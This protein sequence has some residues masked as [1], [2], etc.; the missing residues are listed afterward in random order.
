MHDVMVLA[1]IRDVIGSHVVAT[2]HVVILAHHI[3]SVPHF[4]LSKAFR[5]RI[6]TVDFTGVLWARLTRG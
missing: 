6:A 5:Y 4:A 3:A 2:Q 1:V